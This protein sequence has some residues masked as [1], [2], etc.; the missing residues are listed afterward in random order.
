MIRL[1]IAGCF[2]S[3]VLFADVTAEDAAVFPLWDPATPVP[4]ASEAS[5]LEGVRFAV[6]KKHEPTAD[7]YHWLH[8]LALAWHQDILYAF[9]GHNKS[10]ENTP[11]EVAQGRHSMDGGNTWSPV[12]MLA[13]NVGHEG[14][15][16]GVLLSHNGVLWAFLARFGAGYGGLK[17]EAFR[18]VNA[19]LSQEDGDVIWESTGIA[20]DDF[21]PCDRPVR[22]DDGNWIMA[23]ARIPDGPGRAFPAVAISH[24]EDF[25]R[26]DKVAM[27]VPD[28]FLDIWGETTTLVEAQEVTAIVRAGGTLD[29]ALVSASR[30]FGR[31]WSPLQRSNLPMPGTKAYAGWLS[32]G[33][34]YV[35]GTFTR[36]HGRLRHPLTIAVSRPGEKQF[37]KLFRIRDDIMSGGPGESVRGCAL[38]YPYAV[39]HEGCLYVA[40]SNDGGRGKNLN[41][42]EMA[43]IPLASLK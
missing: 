14:R 11:S 18:L 38:S 28:D 21:W 34:R 35:I 6:I 17:T 33:Q 23:G 10:E 19:P 32:T 5:L 37:S 26:W 42:A 31:T 40:Y 36:D 43:V 20:V 16:H 24:G 41:S 1:L 8:G 12:W 13:P 29:H 7:G 2:I 25:T 27:P 15:S 39:E 22:M 30:D 4:T 9:W 3:S